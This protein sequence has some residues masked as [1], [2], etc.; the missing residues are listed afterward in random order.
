[1]IETGLATPPCFQN[2][3][4]AISQLDALIE[5]AQGL[6]IVFWGAGRKVPRL[7]D[8]LCGS[9][10]VL[11]WPTFITDSTRPLSEESE[12]GIPVL[13]FDQLK[14]LN[15]KRTLII[16][17][18]G[19]LDLQAHVIRRE[20]YYH[21]ILDHW[22]IEFYLGVRHRLSEMESL[23]ACLEDDLSRY[24]YTERARCV[25]QGSLWNPALFSEDPYF[26]NEIVP[27]LPERDAVVFAGAFNG[28]HI[29]R[30]L[31]NRPTAKISAYEP[32]RTWSVRTAHRFDKQDQ[33][34]V[35]NQILWNEDSTVH[36][37]EDTANNGLA[38]SVVHAPGPDTYEVPTVRIDSEFANE[39]VGQIILDVEGSE[40]A[41]LEGAQSVIVRDAPVITI[42]IYHS[43]D[44]YISIQ[45]QIESILPET[46]KYYVR[47]HS[48]VT[49]IETVLYAVPKIRT[50]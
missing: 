22:T 36:Y 26:G 31:A 9:S 48:C 3:K 43:A 39:V 29:D 23:M 14:E 28:R 20:L 44:D 33:V 25:I 30:M 12:F 8:E 49:S 41:V 24:I 32:S 40:K 7:L 50:S 34:S 45:Q 11:P 38:A 6:Q 10:G 27:M 16:I 35:R 4:A 42:C 18:A 47:Q 2:L 1:M 37:Y 13:P 5:R 15:P 17:T 46:Y 19:L 21:R